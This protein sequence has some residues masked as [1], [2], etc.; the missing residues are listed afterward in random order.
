MEYL[1]HRASPW[2]RVLLKYEIPLRTLLADFYDQLK[3]RTQGYA[4]MDYVLAG[5]RPGRL[6]KL[7]V[8]VH[9]QPVDALS[10]II[11]REEAHSEGKALVEKLRSLIPRQLFDVAI[12]AAVEGRVIA[13]ETVKAM[14]KDVI[15][16]CY[17][18]DV[19]RKRKLLQKQ[20]EGKKKLKRIGQVE[21]P[22]EAFMEV[23]KKT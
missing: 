18:G 7:E 17:G 10:R 5:Y 9:N 14:R 23:L 15:A 16:K 2:E 8:L 13:R 22:Q 20:A 4:S 3:T 21:V 12:Q 19:T 6:V 1:G 11:P